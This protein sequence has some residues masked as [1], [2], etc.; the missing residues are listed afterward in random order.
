MSRSIESML[1][2]PG[3]LGHADVVQLAHGGGGTKMAALIDR[4]F[5][6]AFRNEH[7]AALADGAT[8]AVG[9][10]RLAF[11][12]DTFV[13]KPIFFPGGDIG[14]LA[15]HGTVNDLAMCGALPLYLSAGF[16]LEEA[17][18]VGIRIADADV[19]V[20]PE[21]HGACE[22]LGFDPLYVACEGRFVAVLPEAD[23]DRALAA[24]HAGPDGAQPRR[25][26]R[27]VADDPG[28][29]VL[30]TRIGS[31]RLLERLSGEQ[32]PRIC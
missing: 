27:V 31:H 19:P 3:P 23:T 29:V 12:T 6:P 14:S 2:C 17:S 11:T 13:V 8:L 16:V 20:R 10:E 32:L 21:V 9:G 18:R 26:G 22:L 30:H 24:L 28:R 15:V 7:L 5:L 25:I 1:T 4:V